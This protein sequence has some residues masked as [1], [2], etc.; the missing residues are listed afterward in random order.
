MPFETDKESST[1]RSSLAEDGSKPETKL[2]TFS[3]PPKQEALVA[4]AKSGEELAF[5]ALVKR[6]QPRIF[7]L[8]CATH[9]SRRTQKTLSSKL[10]KKPSSTC[11]NSKGNLL[12]HLV[13]A[14]RHQRGTYVA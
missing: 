3:D 8:R 5:E 1:M 6:H 10:S 11:T 9:A 4:A 2:A 12:L 13:D 7:A 14:H